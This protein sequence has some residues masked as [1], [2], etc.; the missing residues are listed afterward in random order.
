MSALDF[1]S[2][3]RTLC[4][5]IVP[6]FLA[7]TLP[8]HASDPKIRCDL[9]VKT[10]EKHRTTVA[11]E[12]LTELSYEFWSR[13]PWE[14]FPKVSL[15]ALEGRHAVSGTGMSFSS[16]ER[17]TLRSD[18]RTEQV[19]I[20]VSK[21]AAGG[22]SMNSQY[23]R[24]EAAW[25]R[26][27][28]ENGFGPRFHGMTEVGGKRAIVTEFIEGVH[29]GTD[30]GHLHLPAGTNVTQETIDDLIRIKRFCIE[31]GILPGDP[32]FRLTPNGRLVVI[33]P[34]HFSY[35]GPDVIQ[36]FSKDISRDFDALEAELK[37][38]LK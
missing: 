4:L 19:F 3:K 21:A 34:E 23:V 27:L 29:F 18:G 17:A 22:S 16:L 2:K 15:E 12:S 20:K 13:I 9:A 10:I 30:A 38:H 35:V 14:S 36:H 11:T 8:L 5:F 24:R 25:L 6:V 7:A 32:Q 28:N 26:Y 31:K 37:S 33:D 1:L